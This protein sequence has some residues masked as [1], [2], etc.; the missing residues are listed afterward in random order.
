MLFLLSLSTCSSVKGSLLQRVGDEENP[1]TS[2]PDNG[3]YLIE[4][5]IVQLT[6]GRSE[7]QILPGSVSKKI[8]LL[9]SQPT[10]GDL[11]GDGAADTALLLVQQHEGSG[12]F[13]YVTASLLRDGRHSG[14]NAVLLGDRIAPLS[15]LIRKEQI[16]VLYS[17]RRVDESMVATPTIVKARHFRIKD[18]RLEEHLVP[19]A[20][21]S[22]LVSGW[23]T[24]GHEVRSF[25]A[26]HDTEPLWLLG[27]SPALPEIKTAHSEALYLTPP[28]FPIFMMLS[29]VNASRPSDGFG[30]HYGAAFHANRLVEADPRGYCKNE[31]IEVVNPVP[32]SE[33]SSQVTVSGHAR[34]S[35][36]FEGDFPLLLTDAMGQV[37]ARGFATAQGPWMSS[38]WVPF[39]GTLQLPKKNNPDWG[40]IVF[41]KDNPSDKPE[42][43]AS[44]SIPVLLK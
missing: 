44:I 26:C 33:F 15:I 29:G 19:A 32:G 13:Y 8:T 39:S 10:T 9:V 43:D 14:T 6:D 24:L 25:Q 23:L 20:A 35:W 21:D 18:N 7:S 31:L 2:G 28:Y 27:N 40:W 22:R 36:Y 12:S 1:N 37:L 5:Q 16:V 30:S 3:I 42:L 11:V 34:G 41:K 38:D 17:D 4:N